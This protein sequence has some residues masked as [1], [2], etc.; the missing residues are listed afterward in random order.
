VRAGDKED[1]LGNSFSMKRWQHGIV[2]EGSGLGI[3]PI[4]MHRLFRTNANLDL[5]KSETWCQ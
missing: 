4:R 1:A 2:T 3:S 5:S